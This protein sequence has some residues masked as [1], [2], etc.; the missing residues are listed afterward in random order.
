VRYNFA[1]VE[2]ANLGLLPTPIVAEY[3]R[4]IRFL[5]DRSVALIIRSVIKKMCLAHDAQLRTER[6]LQLFETAIGHWWLPVAPGDVVVNAIKGGCIFDAPIVREAE[7]HIRP[8]TVVLDVG[9]NF[10]QMTVLFARLVGPRGHVHAFEAEP[11][12]AG[13]LQKNVEANG[14]SE[15]VTIHRGAVW[16]S[17]GINLVFPQPDL[18]EHGSFGSYGVVPKASEGRAVRSLTIDGLNIAGPISFMK[19]D[20]QGSDLFAMYG[21]RATIG[22]ERMPIIFEFE[23]VFCQAFGTSFSDYADF[24]DSAGYSFVRTIH[25]DGDNFLICPRRELWFDWQDRIIRMAVPCREVARGGVHAGRTFL[26]E[27]PA[28]TRMVKKAIKACKR[29]SR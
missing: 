23:R 8:G 9:A 13:I 29:L 14:V 15:C 17:S 21:A 11:F 12:V 26:K 19:I 20:V 25:L 2:T 22:R 16:H 3:D 28:V 10:G 4:Y 5:K 1:D 18:K 6:E 24:V 27:H 7:R